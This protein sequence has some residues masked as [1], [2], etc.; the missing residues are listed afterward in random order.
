M[1][2]EGGGGR[3]LAPKVQDLSILLLSA[4]QRII[5]LIIITITQSNEPE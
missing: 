2:W 4:E 5:N 1:Q 3:H